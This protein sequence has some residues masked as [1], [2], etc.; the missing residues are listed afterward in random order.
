MLLKSKE[1]TKLSAQAYDRMLAAGWFRGAR[2]MNKPDYICV[3][4]DL[5]SPVHVRLPLLNYQFSKSLRKI[6]HKNDSVFRWVM[7]PAEVDEDAENLYKQQKKDFQ[8]FIYPSLEEA[9]FSSRKVNSFKTYSIR[10]YDEERL[11]AISFFDVGVN[12]MA[13]LLGLYDKRYTKFSLGNYTILKELEIA[14][15]L[16][17]SYYY[18]GYVLSDLKVFSYKLRFGNFQFKSIEGKWKDI[19]KYQLGKTDADHYKAIFNKVVQKLEAYS[20]I[21]KTRIY[22]L[23]Y[24][25]NP[26]FEQAQFYRYP[27]YYE[28][29]FNSEKYAV[30]Y[31]PEKNTIVWSQIVKSPLHQRL[32]I[33]LELSNDLKQYAQY[34]MSLLEAIKEVHVPIEVL[35]HLEIS[36]FTPTGQW[37]DPSTSFNINASFK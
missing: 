16:D 8:A 7:C 35:D 17:L 32:L 13:S 20:I 5:Y 24:A 21:G 26:N 14:Q 36:S 19:S 3:N 6:I 34:E 18:P 27:L 31:D 4:G 23:H 9:L 12:S 2:F 15:R 37:S 10:V 25:F 33:G 22:P 30:S 1:A 29:M 11:I 28:V